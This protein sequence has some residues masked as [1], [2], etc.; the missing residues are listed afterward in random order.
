MAAIPLLQYMNVKFQNN[1][2]I[3]IITATLNNSSTIECCI[4]SLLAQSYKNIEHIVIDGGSNDGTQ[5]Y[6][7]GYSVS[8]DNVV[9]TSEKDSGIYHA[10]NKGL[11]LA[12]GDIIGFLHADDLLACDTILQQIVHQF[13]KNNAQG[14]YGDVQYVKQD[15]ISKVVRHWRCQKYQNTLINK[16][17]M[18]AHTS[19]YLKKEIYELHGD[20]S[21]DFNIAADYEF[22]LRIFKPQESTFSYLPQTVVK[23]R[24][25]GTSNKSIKNIIVKMKEDYTSLQLH[26]IPNSLW[27]LTQKNYSKCKQFN[28]GILSY[29]F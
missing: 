12:T 10:L 4:N 14:V 22:I 16:G 3:S 11:V 5:S 8:H 28:H 24:L 21:T 1:L 9:Y 15:N 25:G 26:K 2:K 6:L 17:W 27:V 20:F 23:M 7:E 18:P 29:F 13:Q 19:L